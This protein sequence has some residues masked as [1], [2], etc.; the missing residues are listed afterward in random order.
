MVEPAG[1]ATADAFARAVLIGLRQPQK[2]I[3]ARFFYDEAGSA[4]F[5]AITQLPEYY[6]T[7]TEAAILADCAAAIAAAVGPGRAVIEYGSG[8]SAKTPLLLRPLAAAAY[9]PVDISGEFL[10]QS[11]AALAVQFPH[12]PILP[13]VADFTRPFALPAQVAARPRLGFFPGSTIGN[14]APGAAIDL[15]RG[16]A[17]LLGPESWL[18]IGFDL[19][20][21][22]G[23]SVATLEAAYDDAAGVTAAFNRNLLHRINRELAGTVRV[24]DFAHRAVWNAALGRIEMHLVAR[25]DTQFTAAG[26]NFRLAAGETIHTENSHKWTPAEIR[27]MAHASGWTPAHAWTDNADR[28]TVQ[29]WRHHDGALQP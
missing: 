22:A 4:L 12:L 2:V 13:V 28:F 7:R 16:F 3:P 5:E 9:V 11:A 1:P 8:S 23:K 29:L 25:R 18:V 21:G 6:P 10:N 14:L 20:P 26:Q 19:A 24:D 27:L 15:L 17:S